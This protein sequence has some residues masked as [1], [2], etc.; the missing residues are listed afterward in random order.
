MITVNAYKDLFLLLYI[1][2]K[3]FFLIMN[4]LTLFNP[5]VDSN[6]SNYITNYSKNNF[7]HSLLLNNSSRKNKKYGGI[8]FDD[9]LYGKCILPHS[10]LK[11]NRVELTILNFFNLIVSSELP[12]LKINEG[13]WFPLNLDKSF[14]IDSYDFENKKF[15]SQKII[16]IYVQKIKEP[17]K[18]ITLTNK[19][20]ILTTQKHRFL[21]SWHGP[22]EIA[23]WQNFLQT[24]DF[25]ATCQNGELKYEEIM[26][27]ENK[28]YQGYVFDLQIENTKNYVA[29]QI[30]CHNT[31]QPV[32]N[33]PTPKNYFKFSKSKK[34]KKLN[35]VICPTCRINF[36]KDN[37]NQEKKMILTHKNQSAKIQDISSD[38]WYL[39][40]NYKYCENNNKWHQNYDFDITQIDIIEDELTTA[41]NNCFW[42]NIF[43]IKSR[44]IWFIYNYSCYFLNNQN[45][46]TNNS[47]TKPK[48]TKNESNYNLKVLDKMLDMLQSEKSNLDMLYNNKKQYPLK[49][50]TKDCKLEFTESENQQY[51]NYLQKFEE[52][53]KSSNLEFKDDIYLQKFCSFPQS[54]LTINYFTLDL[55]SEPKTFEKSQNMMNMLGNYGDVLLDNLMSSDNIISECNIC[56][57]PIHHHNLGVTECGHVFCY[58]CLIK[59]SRFHKKCP[60]CRH[61]IHDE[62]IYLYIQNWK[63]SEIIQQHIIN[64]CQDELK[65]GTKISSLIKLVLN[66]KKSKIIMSNFDDNLNYISQILGQFNIPCFLVNNKNYTKIEQLESDKTIILINYNFKFYKLPSQSKVKYILFNEPYYPNFNYQLES[67]ISSKILWKSKLDTLCSIFPKSNIYRLYVSNSI[68]QTQINYLDSIIY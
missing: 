62:N 13:Q 16:A 31:S 41:K 50:R 54:N 17:I 37:Y 53:Y 6:E 18:K 46:I 3:I 56:L 8:L 32:L 20:N 22:D 14:V 55:D 48:Y 42:K 12:E 28:N 51:Q 21:Q 61:P 45:L 10:K 11:I 38:T 64:K 9:N 29:N 1:N 59:N 43:N 4:S 49:Q 26:E 25:I 58:S 47:E 33:L 44:C 5:T 24:G 2:L 23:S 39:I 60:R 15:T 34:P 68:E 19:M 52:I 36:W 66:L 40:C 65:L 30:V 57:Q 27:V 7:Y 63:E 67:G 35:L